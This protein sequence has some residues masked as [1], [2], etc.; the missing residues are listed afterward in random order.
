MK[1]NKSW[2]IIIGSFLILG[3]AGL[4]GYDYYSNR[5]IDNQENKAIEEFYQVE[6]Q[7]E[8]IEEP[9]Q[10]E[11]KEE[12]KE[13]KIN[14]IAILK[15]PKIKLV[16]GL[17]DRNSY[18]N[19]VKYNV[20]ILKDSASPEEQNGNVI[21]AAHSGNARISYFRNLDKL[22][23]GDDISL[24]YKSKTYK[25]KIVDIYLIE[26]TGKAE[27]VRNKNKNTLTLITCKHNT[28]K[29][30]VIIAELQVSKLVL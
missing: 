24:E 9:K 16:R 14:Y 28:I 7:E 27:I 17:V 25:Y 19:N 11:V 23:L 15:I 4:I 29:Q 10:E 13:E 6:E 5:M 21:L 26:K 20:E 22:V 12:K 1:R 18:L 2:L 30:I 8:I 3:G